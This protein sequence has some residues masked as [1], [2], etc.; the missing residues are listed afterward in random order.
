MSFTITKQTTSLL[1]PAFFSDEFRQV[2]ESHVE[3]LRSHEDTEVISVD[4]YNARIYRY[5][6]YRYLNAV[7]IPK[8]MHWPLMRLNGMVHPR[9]FDETKKTLYVMNRGDVL[10][11]M[12]TVM[13]QVKSISM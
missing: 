2:F 8:D 3:F 4:E 12:R 6:F 7:G 11:N 9:D 13:R 10:R 5:D 1:P